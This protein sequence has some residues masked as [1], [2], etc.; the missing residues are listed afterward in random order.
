MHKAFKR[1]KQAQQD[2]IRGNE[3]VEIKVEGG[4]LKKWR[5]LRGTR[6]TIKRSCILKGLTQ[7]LNPQHPQDH[8]DVQAIANT[9]HS[10]VHCPLYFQK[11]SK[12]TYYYDGKEIYITVF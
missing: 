7:I 12:Q 11:N 2:V 5:S 9:I 3:V 10:R 8:C 1:I 6:K 4:R